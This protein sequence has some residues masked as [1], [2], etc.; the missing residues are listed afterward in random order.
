MTNDVLSVNV[1]EK[2]LPQSPF[3]LPS[4]QKPACKKSKFET[5]TAWGGVKRFSLKVD[6]V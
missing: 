1:S 4:D 2:I 3:Y 6:L 5:S